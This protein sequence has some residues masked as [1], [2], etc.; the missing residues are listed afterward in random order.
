MRLLTSLTHKQ[1]RSFTLLLTSKVGIFLIHTRSVR[2]PQ[3]ESRYRPNYCLCKNSKLFQCTPCYLHYLIFSK[4]SGKLYRHRGVLRGTWDYPNL[5]LLDL[6]A[7][8]CQSS[9]YACHFSLW[10]SQSANF[11]LLKVELFGLVHFLL[12][13]SSAVTSS[14]YGA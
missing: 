6:M 12:I 3:L 14:Q 11:L 1:C 13:Q 2:Q 4:H 7:L 9:I 5:A 10:V 8:I